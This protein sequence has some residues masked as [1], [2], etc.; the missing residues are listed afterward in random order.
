MNQL[1]IL[2]LLFAPCF[3]TTTGLAQTS[4]LKQIRVAEE[5]RWYLDSKEQESRARD[6]VAKIAS[7][8]LSASRENVFKLLVAASMRQGFYQDTLLKSDSLSQALRNLE[9]SSDP[10]V[11]R[12]LML[13]DLVNMKGN[14]PEVFKF[15]TANPD[16]TAVG[17]PFL[18]H[19]SMAPVFYKG[20]DFVDKI[21]PLVNRYRN[22]QSL[23][24]R[25]P[26]AE[27]VPLFYD[28][29]AAKQL[30]REDDLIKL[31][32]T[33]YSKKNSLGSK[34]SYRFLYLAARAF[35]IK[36]GM[37]PEWPDIRKGS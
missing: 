6:L 4:T 35:R 3:A 23:Y 36:R 19:V 12:Q 8:S 9:R 14:I 11:G 20:H 2:I 7:G 37:K 13:R 16:D 25:F 17:V 29:S 34:E 32:P 22:N 31:L 27:V 33:I 28:W 15:L 21:G 26:L 10:E 1:K 5:A 30:Q 18:I 24:V